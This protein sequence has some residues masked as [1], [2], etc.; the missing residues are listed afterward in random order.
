[1]KVLVDNIEGLLFHQLHSFWIDIDESVIKKYV[2]YALDAVEQNYKDYS[3]TRFCDN[4]E[5]IFSP[6]MSS[7][8][9]FF[10]Y[11]LSHIIYLNNENQYGRGAAD[12]IYYLNKILHSIDWFYAVDLPVHFY[13]EHPLKSVMGRAKY[14]DWL[15]IYQGTTVGGSRKTG[16]VYYPTIGNNVILFSD[17]A[18]LGN[19][20]I[21]DNVMISSGT[22][23]IN[24]DIPANS[25]VFGISPNLIIREYDEKEMKT[26]INEYWR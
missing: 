22:R 24:T 3:N 2:P 25:I 8:W 23:V 18:I 12:Q 5:V 17:S 14:G 11:S 19:S 15:L 20:R 9:M 7:Q 21:G 26:R 13:S 16:K 6:Y 10:L 1:M 4:G